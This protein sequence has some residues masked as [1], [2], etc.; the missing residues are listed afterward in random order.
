M[1]LDP[2]RRVRTPIAP[3]NDQRAPAGMP[4]EGTGFALAFAVAILRSPET[5]RRLVRSGGRQDAGSGPAGV[6][7]PG[8][9]QPISDCAAQIG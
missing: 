7:V 5:A 4:K 9:F 1:R 8:G 3:P 6:R 2:F